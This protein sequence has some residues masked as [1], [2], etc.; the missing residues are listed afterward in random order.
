MNVLIVY[1]HEEPKSFNAALKDRD[2]S[3]Q[4]G[5][6]GKNDLAHAG[7]TTVRY[8]DH[9]APRA[10]IEAMRSRVWADAWI[11]AAPMPFRTL[12]RVDQ[13]PTTSERPLLRRV[14]E[15]KVSITL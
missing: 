15:R 5:I 10:V 9:I 8:L 1:A 12:R 11:H 14:S 6:V 7:I 4:L 13:A 3:I 2:L